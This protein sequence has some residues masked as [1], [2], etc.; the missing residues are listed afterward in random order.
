MKTVAI[1]TAGT[2]LVGSL[3]IIGMWWAAALIIGTDYRRA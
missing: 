3:A 2:L 1:V